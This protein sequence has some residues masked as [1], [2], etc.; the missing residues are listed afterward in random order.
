MPLSSLPDM[1]LAWC[2][3]ACLTSNDV[4]RRTAQ[5]QVN[6][7]W[8]FVVTHA[9]NSINTT[10]VRQTIATDKNPDIL[11]FSCVDVVTS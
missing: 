8:Q 5:Q 11:Y 3:Q 2:M 9:T 7:K 10:L 1:L 4:S 6:S